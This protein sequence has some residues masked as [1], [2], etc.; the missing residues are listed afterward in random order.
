M[1]TDPA[2]RPLRV[3]RTLPARIIGWGLVAA[4]LVLTVLTVQDVLDGHVSGVIAPVAMIVAI[5]AASW[6]LFLRPK[7][8]VFE[9]RVELVNILSDTTVPFAT[10]QEVTHQ[11]A[12][13]LHDTEGHRHSAWAVPVRREYTRRKAI[14]DF[15]ET[16]TR[17]RGSEGVT[18]QGAADHLLRTIERWKDAGGDRP[19]ASPVEPQVTRRVAWPAVAVLALA[20]LLAVLALVG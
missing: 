4:A 18:A 15:A 13:E 10:I 7:A 8:S 9:D 5:A 1:T 19:A 6:V 16:T 3:Y 12:L 17:R 14:D 2:D 20:C 11:W